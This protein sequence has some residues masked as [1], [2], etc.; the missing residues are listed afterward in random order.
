MHIKP[1]ALGLAGAILTGVWYAVEALIFK[2][3]PE[4]SMKYWSLMSLRMDYAP[5]KGPGLDWTAFF[6][7]LVG[8]MICAYV[9]LALLG[10]LYNRLAK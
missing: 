10:W 1:H 7:G 3:A 9:C 5:I 2:Y 4:F 8:W 6:A